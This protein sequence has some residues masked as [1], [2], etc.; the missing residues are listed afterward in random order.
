MSSHL[1]WMLIRNNSSFLVR[2]GHGQTFTTEPNNVSGRNS[3]RFN[4]LVHRK[5]V[6]V[7]PSADKKGVVLTTRKST[8]RHKPAKSLNRATF[9]NAAGPRRVL[10]KIRNT[11]RQ[12]RYRKDLKTAVLRRASALLRAQQPRV[13]KAAAAEKKPAAAKAQ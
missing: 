11:L 1:Q 10:G 2:G 13:A 5:T 4:G 9:Q 8:H 6:G 3:F 12:T 7:A